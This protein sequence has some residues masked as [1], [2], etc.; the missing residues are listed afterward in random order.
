MTFIISSKT[1]GKFIVEID[2][3]DWNKVKE[4]TWYVKTEGRRI[5]A[6]VASTYEKGTG[7]RGKIRLHRLIVP[8][9]IVDHI[10]RNPLNN[11]KCNLREC[12][13]YENQAN[14]NKQINN[15]TGYKG[16]FIMRNKGREYIKAAISSKGKQYHLGIF[17]TKEEAARAYN[18]AALKYHGAF[19]RLNKIKKIKEK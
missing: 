6:V 4:Y 10:D 5:K 8:F 1:R 16:V 7:K 2:D 17:K 14:R 12:S 13:V 11:R 15:T 9:D 3:E 18:K 19:A